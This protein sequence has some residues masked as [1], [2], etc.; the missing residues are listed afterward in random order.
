MLLNKMKKAALILFLCFAFLAVGVKAVNATAYLTVNPTTGNYNINDTFNVTLGV[1]SG[2]EATGGVDGIVVYDSSKLEL[3]S[4]VQADDMVFSN[5]EGGGSCSIKKETGTVSYSCWANDTVGDSTVNGSLVKLTFKATNTGTATLSYT[6][7]TSTKDSNII[8][9]SSIVDIITCSSN[10]T[11]SYI[12]GS[13]SSNTPTPTSSSSTA[14][15]T[16]VSTSLPQTGSTGVTVGLIAVGLMSLF[17]AVFL[18]FL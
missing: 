12:I 15:P 17:S 5:V 2:S 1:N 3:T 11:G 4:A 10:Q 13:G 6:C 16:A 8:G 7:S 14:A 9:V 18:K